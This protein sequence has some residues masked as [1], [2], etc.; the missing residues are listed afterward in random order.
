VTPDPKLL[1]QQ[2]T[3][4]TSEEFS[5]RIH[6]DWWGKCRTC[7]EWDGERVKGFMG[8]CQHPLAAFR[9]CETDSDGPRT[10]DL[11]PCPD[12]ES[13]DE[14]GALAALEWDDLPHH[15]K[16]PVYVSGPQYG[17]MPSGVIVPLKRSNSKVS[18]TP[19]S[20]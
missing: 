13:Y 2:S 10:K 4:E 20:E 16:F 5:L 15:E 7:K 9:G 1:A 3:P 12:W 8:R 19:D 11:R 18:N 6:I 17:R 14:D